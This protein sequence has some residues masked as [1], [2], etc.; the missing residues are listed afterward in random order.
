MRSPRATSAG[1]VITRANVRPGRLDQRSVNQSA[2]TAQAQIDRAARIDREADFQLLLGRHAAAER[3]SH[4]TLALR[5]APFVNGRD[6]DRTTVIAE[7][8][9][10]VRDQPELMAALPELR[11][12]NLVCFCAP[13]ACRG[14]VLLELASA[15]G[16]P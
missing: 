15:A 14:D 4:Q 10:W 12:R 9:G 11:A 5:A 8:R 7:Y 3:L 13:A 2:P 16:V 6:G 1:P